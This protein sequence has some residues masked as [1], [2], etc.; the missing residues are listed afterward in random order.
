METMKEGADLAV[1]EQ[2][3]IENA[4]ERAIA[5]LKW[6]LPLK[7]PMNEEWY[8]LEHLSGTLNITVLHDVV[9][10]TFDQ[11]MRKHHFLPKDDPRKPSKRMVE[12]RMHAM[13]DHLQLRQL[14]QRNAQFGKK[15]LELISSGLVEY[16]APDEE[17]LETIH[18]FIKDNAFQLQQ[19]KNARIFK[20]R[21]LSD[22]EMDL[23]VATHAVDDAKK[24]LA[25]KMEAFRLHQRQIDNE[26]YE[27]NS[28]VQVELTYTN[29]FTEHQLQ[30]MAFTRDHE[31]KAIYSKRLL[32]S[33]CFDYSTIMH[34]ASKELYR[35]MYEEQ[36][37][38]HDQR[39]RVAEAEHDRLEKEQW[40]ETR[41]MKEL[42]KELV[43]SKV[44]IQHHQGVID[45]LRTIRAEEL[46]KEQELLRYMNA[47][48]RIQ[49]WWRYHLCLMA[50][51][52]KQKGKKGKKGKSK[53]GKSKSKKL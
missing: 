1:V 26:V 32:A 34:K 47:V 43:G 8:R 46:M 3:I 37:D 29:E 10:E 16:D 50:N 51:K 27:T 36:Q 24:Q 19:E 49:R 22:A 11:L 41:N 18:R 7:E 42:E 5:K 4:F 23:K 40:Q 2:I 25:V 52:K 53:G 15:L 14:L 44:A 38:N 13:L 48:I 6:L 21:G 33:R 20:E 35:E 39:M 28:R 17:G 12:K 45:E 9:L 31:E 30:L